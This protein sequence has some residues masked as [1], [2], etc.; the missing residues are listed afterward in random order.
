MG[1]EGFLIIPIL[2]LAMMIGLVVMLVKRG[3]IEK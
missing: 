2:F 1:I 3:R